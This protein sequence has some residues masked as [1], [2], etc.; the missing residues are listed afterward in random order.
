MRTH[1][2]IRAARRRGGGV[3]VALRNTTLSEVIAGIGFPPPGDGGVQ[4]SYPLQLHTA[5]Q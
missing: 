5:G 1:G 3:H 4:A 2:S